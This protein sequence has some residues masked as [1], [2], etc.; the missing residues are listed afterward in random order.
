MELG[1]FQERLA[2]HYARLRDLRAEENYSVYAIEH[3]LSAEERASARRLLNGQLQSAR[4]A[5]SAHW[6][7]WI[8]AAAEVGYGYDG[9]EYWDSFADAFPFWPHFGIRNQ[10][11]DW[12][13]RFAAEYR[14]I[15]PSGRWAKQF[16]IIAWPITQAILPR[17]LQRHFSDHLYELR[18]ALAR[19][20]ELTLDEIGDLLS[21]HYYGNSARFEGF[22][23]QKI[24]TARIVI[25]VGLEQV[26][27]AVAPIERETLDRI[28]TDIERIGHSGNRLRETRRVLRDARFVNSHKPGFI[29]RPKDHREVAPVTPKDQS[30][31]VA[32]P[33]EEGRWSLAIAVP[34]LATP[35]RQAGFS[36]R[37]FEQARTRFRL[38]GKSDSW[39][40]GRALFSYTGQSEK[41]LQVYA[42]ASVPIF[43]FE[44]LKKEGRAAIGE[45]VTFAGDSLKLL[46]VQADGAAFEIAGRHVRAD[47]QYLLATASAFAPELVRKLALSPQQTSTASVYLWLLNVPK[48]LGADQI[49]ALESLGLGYVLSARVEPL[50]LVPRW[51]AAT[52]AL[53]FLDS[54]EP[55]FR[56]TADLAVREFLVVIDGASVRVPPAHSGSTLI[57]LGSLAAGRHTMTVCALGAATGGDLAAEDTLMEIRPSMPWQTA[58]AGKAG[59]AFATDP[60][61]C[62]LVELFDRTASIRLRAPPGRTIKLEA[63]FYGANGLIFEEDQLGKFDTS[64]PDDKLTEHV[65]HQLTARAKADRLDRASRIDLLI[66]L[67]EFGSEAITFEKDSEPLRWI[68]I[69]DSTVKLADDSD[70]EV[71]PT[72]KYFALDAIDIPQPLEYEGALKGIQLPGKGALFVAK[73]QNHF[74]RAVITALPRQVSDFAEL[75]IPASVSA[76]ATRPKALINALKS[77]RGARRLMGPMAFLAR[78]NALIALERQLEALLCGEDWRRHA[79]QVRARR[80][81]LTQLYARVYYSR[82]LAA[83]LRAC[84]WHYDTERAA[85][86]AEFV[87][88]AKVYLSKDCP[89]SADEK[90]CRLALKVAFQPSRIGKADLPGGCELDSLKAASPLIRGAYFARL[91]ADLRPRKAMTEVA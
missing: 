43:E 12:Y 73:N 45:L 58:I 51:S 87:R 46:K 53:L 20:G 42:T 86:E 9:T 85:A 62:S 79:D 19:S 10:I 66:S 44:N 40:P 6:L 26:A 1:A 80:S 23:Q 24:L 60:R 75:A 50:G 32:R 14:S 27:D 78:R 71:P 70:A 22:L 34:D 83:G 8:A 91:T 61:E 84:D 21:D 55:M 76:D 65:V 59:I 82:G 15:A 31:L 39:T 37:D 11:R 4:H 41:P 2:S 64:I 7:V 56:I 5:D 35:L 54:E 88:L 29:S 36:P 25:A 57:C 67:D 48:R 77:W 49:G 28:V 69:D 18:H 89:A 33:M 17:Y 81:D 13:K 74:Y 30:R 90:L 68:R 47:Q 16:P 63:R 38:R 72:V 52:G 3:G